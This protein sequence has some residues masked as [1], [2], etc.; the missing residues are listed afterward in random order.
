MISA[1]GRQPRRPGRGIRNEIYSPKLDDVCESCQ[2]S[3]CTRQ[4]KYCNLPDRCLCHNK[5]KS[6]SF[7][8]CKLFF[9]FRSIIRSK[10]RLLD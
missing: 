6:E 4:Y 5:F 7:F 10:S 2:E 3:G 9:K 8:H 1:G